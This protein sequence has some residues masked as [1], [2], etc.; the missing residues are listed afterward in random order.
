MPVDRF[1]FTFDNTTMSDSADDNVLSEKLVPP[2]GDSKQAE[3]YI[4]QLK[5]L[6]D[7]DKV[8]VS[9]TD[10][11]RFDPSTL[12]DHYRLELKDHSVEI[13]HSKHPD[14][15]NDSFVILFTN[16]Q[17][18]RDGCTEKIILAYMHLS[19]DQFKSFALT[20]NQQDQR[21]KKAEETKRLSQALAPVDAV[22]E[23]LSSN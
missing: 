19:P 9:H 21:I 15:G 7:A 8:T 12:Q 18:I 1:V 4:I 11:S 5:A 20:V 16:L 6:V 13:S 3:K 17:N 23:E 14:N 2:S 22:I 10:L